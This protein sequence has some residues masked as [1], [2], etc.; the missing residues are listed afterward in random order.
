MRYVVLSLLLPALWAVAPAS[1][2]IYKHVDEHGN[3]TFTDVPPKNPEQGDALELSTGNDYAEPLASGA[4]PTESQSPARRRSNDA[5]DIEPEEPTPTQ[6][7]SVAITS[8]TPDEAIRDNAGNVTISYMAEPGLDH[9]FGHVARLVLDGQ[10]HST[11]TNSTFALQNLDRGS[12]TA[13]IEILNSEGAPVSAS[14]TIEFHVLRF[15]AL[16]RK[17]AGG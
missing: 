14:A 3:V 13:K 15:S 5:N 2:Q 9:R 12:H 11:T 16:H 6:Y 4:E 10:V 7:T 17:R 1:A 8:P